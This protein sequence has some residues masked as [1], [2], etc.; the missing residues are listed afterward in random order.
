MHSG[1]P[2]PGFDI[3]THLAEASHLKKADLAAQLRVG[4]EH[5]M[6][7]KLKAGASVGVEGV[8]IELDNATEIDK[9]AL[10][11]AKKS[12]QES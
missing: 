6:C 12:S 2:N 5:Y 9:V 1:C 10:Q 8:L 4:F 7:R 11:T 3:E